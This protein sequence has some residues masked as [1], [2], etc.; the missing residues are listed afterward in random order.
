MVPK[1]P[2]LFD[3]DPGF[4]VIKDSVKLLIFKLLISRKKTA[5]DVSLLTFKSYLG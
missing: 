3:F 1:R 4:I 2:I 5:E